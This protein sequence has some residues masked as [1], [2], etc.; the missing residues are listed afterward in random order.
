MPVT[1]LPYA[2][3]CLHTQ[4]QTRIHTCVHTLYTHTQTDGQTDNDVCV[5][6]LSSGPSPASITQFV[7]LKSASRSEQALLPRLL[8]TYDECSFF[9]KKNEYFMYMDI[10]STCISVPGTPGTCRGQK[11]APDPLK[12]VTDGCERHV[13][14]R[15]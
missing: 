2:S 5:P 12:P 3:A 10:L 15:G 13:G 8:G 6:F 14:A 7:I 4:I 11:R 1:F 9:K